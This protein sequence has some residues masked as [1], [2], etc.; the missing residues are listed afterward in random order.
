MET[1]EKISKI[2]EAILDWDEVSTKMR[3]KPKRRLDGCPFLSS[4]VLFSTEK[5]NKRQ[6]TLLH[7]NI[8]FGKESKTTKTPIQFLNLQFQSKE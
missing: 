5:I 2:D 4:D 6:I 3:C 1:K 7:A 8:F